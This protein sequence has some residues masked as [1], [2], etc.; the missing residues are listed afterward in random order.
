[1]FH[2]KVK[3]DKVEVNLFISYGDKVKIE[4]SETGILK[5]ELDFCLQLLDT[6]YGPFMTISSC[7]FHIRLV[8]IFLLYW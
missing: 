5:L 2:K 8:G 1:M 7:S 6:F 4:R 3:I